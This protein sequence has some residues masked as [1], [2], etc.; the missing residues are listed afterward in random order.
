MRAA[1]R[2]LALGEHVALGIEPVQMIPVHGVERAVSVGDDGATPD[3][4]AAGQLGRGACSWIELQTTG[5]PVDRLFLG[6]EIGDHEPRWSVI[7]D[8]LHWVD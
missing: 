2:K 6:R 1:G 7:R 8:G 5:R 3:M 4:I